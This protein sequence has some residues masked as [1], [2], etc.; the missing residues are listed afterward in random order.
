MGNASPITIILTFAML[1]LI[2]GAAY[3]GSTGTLPDTQN[4]IN[5][6]TGNFPTIGTANC[7]FSQNGPTGNC[8]IVDTA[9]LGTIW[10]FASIGSLVFR[11]AAIGVLMIQII[12]IFGIYTSI[13]F[14]GPIFVVFVIMLALYAWSH[15]RG[16]KTEFG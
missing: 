15:I 1:L 6:I 4:T 12:G 5:V 13:P 16:S 7:T 3:A 9:F 8:M 10:L 11:L 14:I 2:F